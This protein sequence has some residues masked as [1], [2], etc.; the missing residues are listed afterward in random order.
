LGCFIGY[1]GLLYFFRWK[2]LHGAD[3]YLGR[4]KLKRGSLLPH[5]IQ[6][7]KSA[8]QPANDT[9]RTP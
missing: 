6:Q 3:A 8:P 4:G 2:C 9:P 7:L 5:Q 1:G